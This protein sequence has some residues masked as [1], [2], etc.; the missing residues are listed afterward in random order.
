[1]SWR[2]GTLLVALAVIGGILAW[3]VLGLP[4]GGSGE[5]AYAQLLVERSV[6]QRS[7]NAVSGVLFDLRALDTLG[8]ALALFAAAAGL[9]IVLRERPGE[10]TRDTPR[11]GRPD[12]RHVQTSALVRAC[13]LAAVPALV[14]LAVFVTV[15]GHLTVGGG[16]QGG[17]LAV[18]AV[19]VVL[20]GGGYGASH[21][22]ASDDRLD[23]EEGIGAGGYVA[24]GLAALALGGAFLANW[25]PLGELG[26]LL[27]GGTI[28]VLSVLV[29]VEARA[30]LVLIARQLTE[31]PLEREGSP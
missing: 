6:E 22:L 16:L 2:S 14:G 19:A 15:R 3:A 10:G 25:L 31:E 9:Q 7:P 27:S 20:L 13:G 21:E 30:A 26:A 4:P 29:A 24:I 1:V 18:A 17:A 8:E 5:G 12:R 23:V 11:E 28:V